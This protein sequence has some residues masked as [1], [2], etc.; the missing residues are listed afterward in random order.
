MLHTTA[1]FPHPG[2]IAYLRGDA[3]KVRIIQHIA[4]E[5]PASVLVAL[6]GGHGRHTFN[7]SANQTVLLQDIFPDPEV[8]LHGSYKAA[9]RAKRA[10]A[11][12]RALA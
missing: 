11:A 3:R 1:E 7:V 4:G 2:S 9:L 8:A 12:G 6:V 10:R 5:Q